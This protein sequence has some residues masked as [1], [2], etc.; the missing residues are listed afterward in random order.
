MYHVAFTPVALCGRV[1]RNP[2]E[3][4]AICELHSGIICYG[5]VFRHVVAEVA[6][7]ELR[8]P[9]ARDCNVHIRHE[10]ASTE[11]DQSRI[12]KFYALVFRCV[13]VKVATDKH[14]P[15]LHMVHVYTAYLIMLN[16]APHATAMRSVPVRVR[17]IVIDKSVIVPAERA[18]R[19]LVVSAVAQYADIVPY[20][21]TVAD[22]VEL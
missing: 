2:A 8:Q 16:D 13:R 17:R 18:T 12:N 9:A 14:E 3:R 1:N 6:P 22:P 4:E 21:R 5:C 19:E 7:G 11:N 10:V 15:G 20:K